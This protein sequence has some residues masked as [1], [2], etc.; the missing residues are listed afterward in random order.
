MRSSSS[1]CGRTVGAGAVISIIRCLSRIGAANSFF[2][3][4]KFQLE[5]LDLL[6]KFCFLRLLLPLLALAVGGEDVGPVFQQLPF[7]GAYQVGMYLVFT[8]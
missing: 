8:G 4:L 6:I 2:E 3:P 7:P 1:P 5:P